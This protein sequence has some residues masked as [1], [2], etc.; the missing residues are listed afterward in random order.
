MYIVIAEDIA[1]TEEQQMSLLILSDT[2]LYIGINMDAFD[3]RW[4]G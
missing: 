3:T 4:A 2:Y 1:M